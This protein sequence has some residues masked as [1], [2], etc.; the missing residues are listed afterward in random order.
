MNCPY[1]GNEKSYVTDVRPSKGNVIRRRKAC[2][3]C[4][5]RFTTIEKILSSED[6]K[7]A[8]LVTLATGKD[9]KYDFVLMMRLR[10]QTDET[11]R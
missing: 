8:K 5:G 2:N 1:C 7:P 3:K 10:K 6:K 9:K 11:Y 4:G